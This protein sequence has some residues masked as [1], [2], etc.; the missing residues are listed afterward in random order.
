MYPD[1]R[2]ARRYP[3]VATAE[4]EGAT[5]VRSARLRDLSSGGAYLAMS[6]PFSKNASIRVK[7][8]TKVDFFQA[9]A[10]VV[11]STHGLGMGVMFHVVPAPFQIVLRQWLSEAHPKVAERT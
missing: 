11:H 6:D 10:T 7:I 4:V 1:R 8:R 9:D 3:F 2:C 5:E